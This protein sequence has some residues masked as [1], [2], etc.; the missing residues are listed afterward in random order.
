MNTTRLSPP[1]PRRPRPRGSLAALACWVFAPA[2]TPSPPATESDR[3]PTPQPLNIPTSTP[4][5]PTPTPLPSPSTQPDDGNPDEPVFITGDIPYTSPFFVDS[6]SEA[7]VLLEDQAGFVNRDREFIFPLEGQAIGP[8]EVL[9]DE[10]VRYSLSLPAIPQGTFV[11]V[12]NNGAEDTGVQVFA[13]AYWGNTWGGPFLEERD[14]GAWSTGHVSTVVDPEQ[15]GEIVGGILIVW[16]PDGEQAFPTG[17][18]EDNLLFTGDDPAGPIPAGYN[19]VRLDEEPFRVWKEARPEITLNEGAS[20]VNDYTDMSYTEAFDALFEKVSREYPFTEDK[21]IDWQA[22]YDEIAPQVA[23]ARDDQD[24]HAA[25]KNFTLAI[26]DAHVGLSFDGQ[27]FYDNYGGSFGMRLAELSDGRVI[28]IDVLPGTES[29]RAGIKI[30]AE[31]IEWDG[32][33]ASQTLDE[34]VSYFG[35]YSTAHS[36]RLDKLIFLTRYPPNTTIEVTFQNPGGTAQQASLLAGVEYDSLFDSIPSFTFDELAL[37]VGAE[38]LD[39]SGLGYIRITTFSDDYNLMAQLWDRFIETLIEEEVPGLIIDVRVNGGGSGGLASDFAG[40]F[41]DEEVEISRRSYYNDISGVFE[42]LDFIGKIH[43][44]P[45]LYEGEV[46]VL[47]SPDCVSACEGFA[48]MMSQQGRA[49]IVGHFPTAGAF[50]E[51]GQGQYDMPGDYSMQFPTGRPET[52]DG[53]LL[54]EGTGVIPG[55]LVPVTFESA[56]GQVDAVLEAAIEALTN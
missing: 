35:P 8:V 9:D 25:L 46:I 22:L 37:P 24:F 3:T 21:G 33:P 54:I 16:A 38:I 14:A 47:V 6:L 2:P 48:H 28:V 15:H 36:E 7:L 13:V 56:L 20:A 43:P 29:D 1:P 18:G 44:A 31:I 39:E 19:L 27:I 12:D 4:A 23:A 34:V 42:Y 5:P 45:A 10:T 30:G 51:V 17:F 50:G 32:Q 49:T 41:F 26:P 55:I 52:P 11:D 53:E 40:Y